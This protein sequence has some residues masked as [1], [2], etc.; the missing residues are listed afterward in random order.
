M[1][2]RAGDIVIGLGGSANE[3]SQRNWFCHTA[4]SEVMLFW[5]LVFTP[6]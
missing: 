1:N 4:A 5:R 3:G 2:D 6:I